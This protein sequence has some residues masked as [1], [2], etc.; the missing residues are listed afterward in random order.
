MTSSESRSLPLVEWHA[1]YTEGGVH[2]ETFL[3]PDSFPLAELAFM[4]RHPKA[5]YWE[6]GR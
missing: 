2:E 5:E 6:I 1:V 3:A 4:E